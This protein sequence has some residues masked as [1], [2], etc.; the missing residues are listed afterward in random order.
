MLVLSQ[1]AGTVRRWYN[2][3]GG[4]SF[5]QPHERGE[6]V[7]VHHTGIA[8]HTT[9]AESLY[10]GTRVVYEVAQQGAGGLLG[11]WVCVNKGFSATRLHKNSPAA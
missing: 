8:A 2:G 5:I 10:E 11:N 9:K 3:E 1:R 4:Y 7:F 6:V